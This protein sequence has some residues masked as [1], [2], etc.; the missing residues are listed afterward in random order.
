MADGY[1][2]RGEIYGVRMDAGFGSEQGYFR[3]GVVVSSDIGNRTN[4]TVNMCFTTTKPKDMGIN[5]STMASGRESWVLCN[6]IATVDKSRLGTM[7]GKLNPYEM[8]K[9]DKCLEKVFD[10]GY[11]DEE[12][13][14]EI[15]TLKTE[16]AGLQTDIEILK[17]QLA[18]KDEEKKD[19][20]LSLRV[21]SEMWQK[22]Y[23]KALDQVVNMKLGADVAIRTEK[24]TPAVVIP[25]PVVVKPEPPVVTET[26]PEPDKVDINHCTQTAL[27]K[28]GFSLPMSRLI[29]SYRPFDN[30]TGLKRV[31]GMKASFYRIVE[32]KL[33]CTPMEVEP[34][35][36]VAVKREPDPGYEETEEQPKPKVKPE[37]DGIKVN[38]NTVTTAKELMQRTGLSIHAAQGVLRY[39]KEHGPFETLEDL[40]KA[41]GF[42]KLAMK[43]YGHMLEV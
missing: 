32:P 2:E 11:V 20:L 22:L 18:A 34:E 39:R 33:C 37:W 5:F 43:R 6:Q 16:K 8:K 9:L 4:P 38:V 24:K 21:E 3:P 29:V 36:V 19:E 25:E 30:V 10:L 41:D 27:R 15:E 13:E 7:M 42:G 23:M 28:M 12:T 26:A 17:A 40:L 1:F 31:P 35:K 14:K